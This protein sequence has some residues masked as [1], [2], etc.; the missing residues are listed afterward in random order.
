MFEMICNMQKEF[1]EQIKR[2]QPVYFLDAL[3]H[4]WPFH[5]DCVRSAEVCSTLLSII[6]FLINSAFDCPPQSRV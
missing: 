4:E 3:G 5:L 1:A 6:R 2:Q